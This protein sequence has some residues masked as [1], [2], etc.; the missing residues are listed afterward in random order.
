MLFLTNVKRRKMYNIGY[1]IR[2]GT[3]PSKSKLL[4]YQNSN[5]FMAPL[6]RP[7]KD[8]II[9]FLCSVHS[10]LFYVYH[11]NVFSLLQSANGRRTQNI[12]SNSLSSPCR[13]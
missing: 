9:L 12:L 3:I 5:L 4:C 6:T 11:I 8:I 10:V 2:K 7:N 13:L 1:N